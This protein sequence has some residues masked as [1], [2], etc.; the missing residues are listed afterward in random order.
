[1]IPPVVREGIDGVVNLLRSGQQPDYIEL[2][3]SV[4]R[5]KTGLAA[6]AGLLILLF[7]LLKGLCMYFMRMTIIIMSRHIEYDQ[8]NDILQPYEDYIERVLDQF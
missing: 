2:L 7:A 5:S 8:K 6:F 1:M 3:P 4:F